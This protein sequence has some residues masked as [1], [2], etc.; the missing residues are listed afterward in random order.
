MGQL[1]RDTAGATPLIEVPMKYG[2]FQEASDMM[3]DFQWLGSRR[4]SRR[5]YPGRTQSVKPL[6]E[7]DEI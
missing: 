5:T 4:E 7:K 3:E 1:I 6:D 2:T